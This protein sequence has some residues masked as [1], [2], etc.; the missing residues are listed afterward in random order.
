MGAEIVFQS[1]ASIDDFI[2]NLVYLCHSCKC[3]K[4][5]RKFPQFFDLTACLIIFSFPV[6][7]R[8]TSPPSTNIPTALVPSSTA[9]ITVH[10]RY[11]VSIRKTKCKE[12]RK[13]N[14][15]PRSHVFPW[16]HYF[17]SHECLQYK[18]PPRAS[19]DQSGQCKRE[20]HRRLT[21]NSLPTDLS[22]F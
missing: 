8:Y 14:C 12:L 18:Q 10:C 17:I 13:W 5:C 21:E 7:C 9:V 3:V 16:R 2:P 11:Q 1:P 20:K 22:L 19:S 15:S 4:I 6:T